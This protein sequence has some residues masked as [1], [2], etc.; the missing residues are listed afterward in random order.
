MLVQGDHSAKV[1]LND[2]ESNSC[3]HAC[4]SVGFLNWPCS[5]VHV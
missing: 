4:M 2:T 1:Q 3:M 5:I